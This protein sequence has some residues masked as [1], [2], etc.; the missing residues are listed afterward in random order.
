MQMPMYVEVWNIM[1]FN[2]DVP[3]PN[4]QEQPRFS[5]LF[6]GILLSKFR[7][8]VFFPLGGEVNSI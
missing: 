6:L 2:L 5:E 8:T 3:E 4:K 1:A 7:F